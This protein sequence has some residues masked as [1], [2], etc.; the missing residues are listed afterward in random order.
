MTIYFLT[1]AIL[2]FFTL[3]Y[4]LL[5]KLTPSFC[6]TLATIIVLFYWRP[7]K[8]RL[9]RATS[10]F[11]KVSKFFTSVYSSNF[12]ASDFF[13]LIKFRTRGTFNFIFVGFNLV[14]V[15]NTNVSVREAILMWVFSFFIILNWL[16]FFVRDSVIIKYLFL[17][18]KIVVTSGARI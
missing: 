12:V 18:S 1:T 13:D 8:F 16:D 17:W 10:F 15:H 3:I 7:I 9:T 14:R 2:F 5:W 4:F 6:L 11:C